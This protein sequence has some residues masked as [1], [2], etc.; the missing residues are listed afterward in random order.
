MSIKDLW[1]KL[2]DKKMEIGILLLIIGPL[3]TVLAV[4]G[5][6]GGNPPD[7]LAGAVAAIGNWYLWFW[8]L[9]PLAIIFGIY[10]T[11]TPWKNRKKFEEMMKITSKSKFVSQIDEIEEL[12]W[13]LTRKDRQRVVAK[14]A[15]MKLKRR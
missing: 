10:Y 14:K 1:L 6:S 15:E 3:L 11:Y 8:L 5:G 4:F 12:A 13:K 7:F 9:G 2:D